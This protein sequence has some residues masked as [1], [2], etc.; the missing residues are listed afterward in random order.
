MC[1]ES[2][3][4]VGLHQAIG[5]L[6]NTDAIVVLVGPEGGWT[7]QEVDEARSQGFTTISLGPHILRTETAAMTIVGLIRYS[8]GA[9]DPQNT[10]H[11]V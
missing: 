8:C 3:Q 6:S 4:Q 10:Q 2:E 1:W 5:P 7:P 9:F 11:D